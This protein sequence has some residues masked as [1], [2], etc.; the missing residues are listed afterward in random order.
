MPQSRPLG[1]PVLLPGQTNE[2][3]GGI[4]YLVHRFQVYLTRDCVAQHLDLLLWA[5]DL[6]PYIHSATWNLLTGYA[7]TEAILAEEYTL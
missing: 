6:A 4:Q 2:V 1:T 5:P 7:D 3:P